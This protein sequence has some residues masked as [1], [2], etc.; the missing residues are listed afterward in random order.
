M[1]AE[2]HRTPESPALGRVDRLLGLFTRVRAGEGVPALLLSLEVCVLLCAYYVLKPVREALILASPGGAE[3]KSYA[4][5]GQIALLAAIVPGYSVLVTRFERSRLIGAVTLVFVA[6]LV[7]FYFLARFSVPGL[8]LAF[9]LWVGIFNL[10]VVAQFWAFASDL[11]SREQGERLFPVV[12]FGASVGAVAG[13][14]LTSVLVEPL[15]VAQMMLVSGA[16]L[17]LAY[18]LGRKAEARAAPMA[19][20]AMARE[21]DARV[22]R[23]QKTARG[24]FRLVWTSRYLLLL[25]FLMLL[26]NFVS[27]TGEFLLGSFVQQRALEVAPGDVTTF[28]SAFYSDFYFWVNS[29]GVF[30]QLFVTSRFIQ[31][32]GVRYALLAL[33]VIALAGNLLIVFVPLLLVVRWTKTA[34]NALDYSLNNTARNTLFLPLTAD[35]KYKAKQVVDT[36]F[37]RAGDVL[38]AGLVFLGRQIFDFSLTMFALVNGVVVVLWLLVAWRLGRAYEDLATDPGVKPVAQ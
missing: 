24:A 29:A 36:V 15:G 2:S 33:P 18:V 14:Q 31:H 38:S 1:T 20:A 19:S 28:I 27:T 34:M 9:F 25:C 17:L 23:E 12:A 6:C 5:V 30:I 22:P 21:S 10:M 7:A 13:S 35:E 37:V 3:L 32:L 16:L 11:F 4:A 26:L 8:G